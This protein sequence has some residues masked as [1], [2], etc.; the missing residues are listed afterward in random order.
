MKYE[1][2]TN[3]IEREEKRKQAEEAEKDFTNTAGFYFMCIAVGLV[4]AW[5]YMVWK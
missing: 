2:H 3:F 1:R 4:M 5:A